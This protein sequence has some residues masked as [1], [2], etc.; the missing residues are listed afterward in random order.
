MS[1]KVDQKITGKRN[2][3]W[4]EDAE[5]GDF[6]ICGQS[7]FSHSIYWVRRRQV[8]E[9]IRGQNA[10]YMPGAKNPPHHHYEDLRSRKLET[11]PGLICERELSPHFFDHYIVEDNRDHHFFMVMTPWYHRHCWG[12]GEQLWWSRLDQLLWISRGPLPKAKLPIVTF[13]GKQRKIP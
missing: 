2:C 13:L 3:E 6:V 8:D 10:A 12:F 9:L 5:W 11:C 4:L 7:L 1:Q